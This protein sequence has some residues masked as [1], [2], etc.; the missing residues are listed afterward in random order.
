MRKILACTAIAL[1]AMLSA[2]SH[3]GNS[4][5][6]SGQNAISPNDSLRQKAM[7]EQQ[8]VPSTFIAPKHPGHIAETPESV[9]RPTGILESGQ[10]PVPGGMFDILNQYSTMR[11]GQY[12]TVY[13]GSLKTTGAGVLL[14]V[15]RSA[16]LH[17]A[18]AQ[19]VT[20]APSAVRIAGVS[21]GQLELQTMGG[22]PQHIPFRMPL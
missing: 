20:V 1:A 9:N 8:R 3:G 6:P 7:R 2:C 21:D 18:H 13:A 14:V 5:L 16:D 19:T 22:Q 12:V 4:A 17:T 11:S 15:T 10:A